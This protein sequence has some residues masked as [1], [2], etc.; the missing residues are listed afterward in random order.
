M[1]TIKNNNIKNKWSRERSSPFRSWG[2][3][4]PNSLPHFPSKWRFPVPLRGW[5]LQSPFHGFLPKL[6]YP[7]EK[8][9]ILNLTFSFSILMFKVTGTIDKQPVA[10]RWC[11]QMIHILFSFWATPS[12][13]RK[14]CVR[15]SLVHFRGRYGFEE[16]GG[17]LIKL[18]I[19]TEYPVFFDSVVFLLFCPT[20]E[21]FNYPFCRAFIL[22]FFVN[23]IRFV[24]LLLKRKRSSNIN[25]QNRRKRRQVSCILWSLK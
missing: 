12:R 4:F 16:T 14:S 18:K 11:S 13:K 5:F 1:C 24:E 3:F 23:F 2:N 25:F 19:E 21:V 8:E 7:L 17:H 10:D 15:I 6:Q 22:S 20:R 9:W